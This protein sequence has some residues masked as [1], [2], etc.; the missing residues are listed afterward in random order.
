MKKICIVCVVVL[1]CLLVCFSA[2]AD[3][4]TP[5]I[6]IAPSIDFKTALTIIVSAVLSALSFIFLWWRHKK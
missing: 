3:V 4:A 6:P 2:F 5:G 1:L